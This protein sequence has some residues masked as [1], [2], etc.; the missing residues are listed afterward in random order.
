MMTEQKNAQKVKITAIRQTVYPDLMQRFEN[1]IEHTCDVREGQVWISED[2]KCPEGMC[3]SAWSSMR[4]FVESLARGE[5]NFYDGWMKNPMS[6]MI[7]CNDGF[8]TLKR[9]TS[10]ALLESTL[11]KRENVKRLTN[12]E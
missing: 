8:S 11:K 3:P 1:P 7:S 5:G 6:A 4:E 9:W 10:R 2:G 12:K